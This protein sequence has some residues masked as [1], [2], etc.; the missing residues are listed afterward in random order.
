MA[1]LGKIRR[2]RGRL[3]QLM[4]NMLEFKD[5]LEAPRFVP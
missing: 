1:A 5:L 2:E 4:A 3:P